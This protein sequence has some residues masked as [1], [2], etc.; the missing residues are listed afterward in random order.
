MRPSQDRGFTLIEVIF[1]VALIG[2]LMMVVL[3][4]FDQGVLSKYTVKTQAHRFVSDLNLVRFMAISE[5]LNYLI[6]VDS[7]TH[8]YAIYKGSLGAE[9]L[10][11]PTR[12]FAPGMTVT[13]DTVFTFLPTGD[14]DPG[15]GTTLTLAKGGYSWKVT[16]VLA[17]GRSA[18][19]QL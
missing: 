8:T 14:A 6:Q 5:H 17:T 13:G 10:V 9:N 19:T 1:G 11:L 15:S 2:I 18:M 4:R 16:V 12:S 7:T 3:P